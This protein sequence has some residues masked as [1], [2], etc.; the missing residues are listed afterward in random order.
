MLLFGCLL[1]GFVDLVM[2]AKG[3]SVSKTTTKTTTVKT[4]EKKVYSL[5]GQKFD[6]PEEVYEHEHEHEPFFRAFGRGL[7][8]P[9][10]L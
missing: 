9:N 10:W 1:N 2:K 7:C 3:K 4:R 6:V 8:E 5:P